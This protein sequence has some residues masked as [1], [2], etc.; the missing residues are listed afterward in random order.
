MGVVGNLVGLGDGIRE[1][2]GVGIGVA[3]DPVGAGEGMADGMA[4]GEGDGIIE[5]LV[6]GYGVV[7]DIVGET[8]GMG[9]GEQESQ[10]SVN[11]VLI[12][13]IALNSYTLQSSVAMGGVFCHGSSSPLKMATLPLAEMI[14]HFSEV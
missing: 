11:S 7:G 1:G 10:K 14:A 12:S 13:V 4:V 2:E 5:G 6:V 3:G 9:V 8:V